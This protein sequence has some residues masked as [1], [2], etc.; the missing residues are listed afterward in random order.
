MHLQAAQIS[1]AE[2]ICEQHATAGGMYF[3]LIRLN[4]EKSLNAL[5]T[6]MVESIESALCH[7]EQDPEIAFVFLMG[8]GNRAFCAG[9]D[10]RSMYDSIQQ[11]GKGA[12]NPQVEQFFS[13]EYRL[14]FHIHTYRKPLIV[15]GHGVVM[16]GGMGLMNGATFRIVTPSTRMAMPEISIGLFPDVGASWF[17]NRLP[18]GLGHVLAL[19][20]LNLNATDALWCGWADYLLGDE[21]LE[22]TLESL[23]ASEFSHDAPYNCRM[24]A[25]IFQSLHDRHNDAQSEEPSRLAAHAP[26]LRSLG[27]GFS[28]EEIVARILTLRD[29]SDSWLQQGAHQLEKGCPLT[30]ALVV[31]QLACSKHLSLAQCFRMER[32]MAINC[33]QFGDLAEGVRALLID[34]D[35]Q[36]HWQ[37]ENWL[38]IDVSAYFSWPK[39][40]GTD[41]NPLSDLI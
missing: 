18:S 11:C 7:Y 12:R 40:W 35:R 39:Q 19:T 15:W 8:K 28:V 26:L 17:L 4:A 41:P 32:L 20:G 6:L 2:V 27:R 14:D 22:D 1:C 38:G 34:K 25:Y 23:R 37:H 30:A 16:G 31:A 10:I 24:L 9:G 5:T 36:P 29:H 33:C 21:Q 3:G 13:Q